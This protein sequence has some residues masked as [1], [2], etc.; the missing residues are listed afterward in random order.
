MKHHRF[1][2]FLVLMLAYVHVSSQ[3]QVSEAGLRLG[4]QWTTIEFE[5]P[6]ERGWI[7]SY[8]IGAYVDY[9]YSEQIS[10]QPSL[11]LSRR[12]FSTVV[13]EVNAVNEVIN[14]FDVVSE[15][16]YLS[17]ALMAHYS[18]LDIN[19]DVY[20]AAGPRVDF[21]L[22]SETKEVRF[23]NE[24]VPARPVQNLEPIVFGTAVEAGIKRISLYNLLLRVGIRY[25]FD[26]TS[27]FEGTETARNQ[28]LAI[29]LGV[30]WDLGK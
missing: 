30:G 1:I 9:A 18:L 17:L 23:S 22:N 20:V 29:T 11:G 28:A 5:A 12:G 15:I 7:A 14:S 19:E 8:Y 27:A 25:E 26:L 2:L 24:V 6:V 16:N 4:P 10:V 3:A 21:M 13:D